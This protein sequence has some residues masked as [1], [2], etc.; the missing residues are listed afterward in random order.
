MSQKQTEKPQDKKPRPQGDTG[1]NTDLDI[2]IGSDETD[3]ILQ[4]LDIMQHPEKYTV[5]Q[6]ECGCARPSKKGGFR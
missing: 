4:E 2:D 3:A 1:P 6:R 5:E